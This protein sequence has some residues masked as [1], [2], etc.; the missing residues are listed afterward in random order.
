LSKPVALGE[1]S[2]GIIKKVWGGNIS[3]GKYCS[4]AGNVSAVVLAD[5]RTDWVSTYP[6]KKKW[7]LNYGERP[8]TTQD[9]D[10]IVENDVWIGMN[11]V[12]LEH[13]HIC[14]GAVIGSHSVVAGEIPP[15]SIA[16]GNPARVVR[17]RFTDEQI[18]DL[19]K[20]AWWNWPDEKVLEYVPL[21]CNTDIDRF[22]KK[23]K[24]EMNG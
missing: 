17:K 20:I 21:L 9:P 6:F 10:I 5:H 23:A 18:E 19:L 1:H 13:T 4:I 14:N 11:A 3:V 8:L 7:A 22:I 2:Y 15:Y 16:V 12:L 24:G